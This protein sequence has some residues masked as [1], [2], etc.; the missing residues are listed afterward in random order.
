M[1]QS[2]QPKSREKE[3]EMTEEVAVLP[4]VAETVTVGHEMRET[5]RVQVV[6]TIAEFQENITLPTYFTEA[7]VTHIPINRLIEG[8]TPEVRQHGDTLIVPVLEEVLITQ[9]RLMLREEIHIALR[10][11]EESRQE[12]VTLHREVVSVLRDT[13]PSAVPPQTTQ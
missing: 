12:T 2:N 9:K 13:V 7:E 5:G 4:V 3:S 1:E 6:K 11:R 10:R 8:E